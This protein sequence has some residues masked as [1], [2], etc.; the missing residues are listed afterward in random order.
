MLEEKPEEVMDTK[1]NWEGKAL[2][3]VQAVPLVLNG[4]CQSC[5]FFRSQKRSIILGE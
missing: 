1:Y 4:S 5:I 3:F 2:I